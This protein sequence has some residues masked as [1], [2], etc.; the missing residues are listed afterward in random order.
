MEIEEHAG[1]RLESLV[2]NVLDWQYMHGSLL[3]LPPDSG[4]ILA[5]PVDV[6]LFPCP[7]PKDLYEIGRDVQTIYN[8]LYVAV[9]RDE[10]WLSEILRNLIDSDSFVSTL[11]KLYEE[12]KKEGRAQAFS[13]A[14]FRSDYMLHVDYDNANRPLPPQL[15]QVELNTFS[16]AGG[17]HSARVSEMHQYLNRIGSY[18]PFDTLIP[19]EALPTNPTIYLLTEALQAAHASYVS[20]K[21]TDGIRRAVLMPVQPNNVNICDERPIEEILWNHNIPTHRV[22]LEDILESTSLS[23]SGEL[24]FQSPH[25]GERLE[26]SVIYYRAG[27]DEE[28]YT[29]TGM[30]ARL[31]LEKS[32]A[33]KCPS[34]QVQIAGSKKV[35]QELSMPGVLERF[36]APEEAARIRETFMPMYPLDGSDAGRRGRELALNVMPAEKHVLKPSLEGGGHN[37]YGTAIP[38]FLRSLPQESWRNYILMEKIAPPTHELSS[39]VSFRGLYSGPVVSE[40]GV[41]GVCL[42]AEDEGGEMETRENSYAGFSLKMKAVGVDEMS[43]VKGYGC[44]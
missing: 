23:P 10:E 1:D 33:I 7:Y 17:V 13:L 14:I 22:E 42:W 11:W 38:E 35:Q 30:A 12:V 19:Q 3:K 43:V 2:N 15:K 39:L 5:R 37:V 24:I 9:A 36:L 16:V 34:L 32:K 29:P 8:K 6:S 4:Q 25:T 28:E 18:V 40:L 27:Y 41:F 44:F 20:S 21:P 26:I 31:Q